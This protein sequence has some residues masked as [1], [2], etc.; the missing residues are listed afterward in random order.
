MARQKQKSALAKA[1][2]DLFDRLS[3]SIEYCNRFRWT[4]M[5]I[6][7]VDSD[8]PEKSSMGTDIHRLLHGNDID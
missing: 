3:A 6:P 1:N 7:N 4:K 2:A 5:A 8:L